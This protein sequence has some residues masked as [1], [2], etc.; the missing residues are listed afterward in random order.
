MRRS[1]AAA[2][3]VAAAA[4]A[5][6]AVA[7]GTHWTR[8][9]CWSSVGRTFGRP[10][11]N[12]DTA[13]VLSFP[14]NQRPGRPL[15]HSCV[16]EEEKE[17]DYADITSSHW[18]LATVDPIS[19]TEMLFVD[20]TECCCRDVTCPLGWCC[21]CFCCGRKPQPLNATTCGWPISALVQLLVAKEEEEE[22]EATTSACIGGWGKSE[23]GQLWNTWGNFETTL[24]LFKCI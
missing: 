7:E 11:Y 19:S 18:W 8:E 24:F 13:E 23:Q 12:Q 17:D 16:E 4:T 14:M 3:A 2:D 9:H 22:E 1:T 10:A 21:Y 6:A 5:A 15:N 20:G